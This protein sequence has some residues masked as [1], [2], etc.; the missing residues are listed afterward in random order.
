MPHEYR[1]MLE[2]ASMLPR[3]VWWWFAAVLV[4][5]F[6]GIGWVIHARSGARKHPA[7]KGKKHIPR[8]NRTRRRN[9]SGT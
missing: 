6:A 9:R 3:S 4:A 2:N 8:K 1:A 7:E 5:T